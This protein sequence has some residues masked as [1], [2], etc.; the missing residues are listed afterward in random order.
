MII[1][2][3]RVQLNREFN[4]YNLIE[5]M[6]Y[7]KELGVSHLYLSPILKAKP[8]STHGYDVVDHSK[9]NEELGGEEG[10]FKL[11]KE[12]KS[13]G[14][15]I[16]QDIVPNHMAVHHTNWRLMDLLK[17]WKISK[18][19]N[20][21]DHYDEDKII[22]PILEDELDV[23]IE[24]GLIKVDKDKIEY[25]GLILPINDEGVEFLKKINCF[26]NSCL[27]K[28]D[29]KRLLLMQY[30]KLTYWKKGSPNYRRF[31]AVNDLIA[32]KVELD[33][34]FRE[35]HELIG[36]LPIDGLR[37]DHIDG[38]YDPKEY[39][40]K[41][42]QLVG[43]DKIIYV[44]K[45]LTIDEKLRDDWKVNGTT[46]YDFLNYVNMLL[47]DRNSEEELTKFYESFI[48]REINIDELIIQSK[49]LVANQLFKDDIE[50]LS[51]LLNVDY[52][53]L[54]D[55]LA[56]MKK[57]RT[58]VPYEDINSIRE[59]D[60][61]RRIKDVK[62][63]MRLQQYMPAIFAK[64]Y[65]DTALFIYNRL[66]SLNEVGSDL[67]KFSISLEEFHNFNLSRV[68]TTSMNTLSTHDTKFSED[69]RA[70]IS[71]LSEIP[72]EWEERVIYW[73]DLLKPSIDKNDE[74]RFYQT[75]VGCYEGFDNKVRERIKNHMIKVIRE[76]KVHTTWENPNTE[77]ENKVLNFI[78]DTFEN[79]S[80]R[81]DFEKFELKIAYFGYMKSLVAT[82]IKFLSPG[83]PDIYQG[84]EVWRFLL[85]DP[86]NRMPVDF[87]KL[88][89]LLNNLTEKKLELSDPRVKMFY[90]KRLLQLRR[91]YSLNDY[92]PLPFGFQ[93]G[94]ITLLFS[95]MVTK[96]VREKIIIRQKSLDL[97]RNEEV[98]SG[99]YNLNELIGEH[100]VIILAE[101]G[102]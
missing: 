52:N 35:S 102:K 82:T 36:K 42:R 98:S 72:K 46:G 4:F 94:K 67:R 9:I 81:K 92:K 28:E 25:R 14:L 26:D 17:N 50:R 85:T 74:Y 64:G 27:T 73:H 33:E 24:K 65:E 75:L 47:V 37:I 96:E 30:Y 29:I 41:L 93:R 95:P 84:T 8:G 71:V 2:T 101:K 54:V 57:Y 86:D 99:E 20:Y 70:R 16:I 78:D 58:Y 60:K 88:R 44:E 10:Y 53:Y 80:F 5:N 6:D 100:K 51:K 18:Y 61:E 34:V 40:D 83:V 55:F 32:V 1:G 39:L 62:K 11:I 19:Y 38:L 97:I 21:F 87:K 89:E 76:A 56:C 59:C 79:V 63:I 7:F 43:N 22:L 77:Y 31:F 23:V 49:R 3:Y 91:E 15:G 12:A 90:V 66:I 68:N 48:G 69:V 45:I 13:R